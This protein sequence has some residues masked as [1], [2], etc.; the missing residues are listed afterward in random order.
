MGLADKFR[1]LLEGSKLDVNRRFE[2]MREAISGTMSKFYMAKD[3]QTGEVFGLKVCNKQKTDY[4]ENRFA[5]LNK[6]SEGEIASQFDHPLIVTTFKY[7]KTTEGED[8]VLM[9]Y[10]EGS[11]LNSLILHQSEKLNG[12]RARLIQQIVEALQ[13]VHEAGFIHRDVCPRNFIASP[14]ATSIKLIDFGLTVPALPL[15]MQPGNRT[16]TP[17]YM[18]PE[19]VRRR[20]TDKRLDL[21]AFGVT[22]FQLLTRE[23]PWPGV[24]VTGKAAMAHDAMPPREIFELRPKLDR[25]LGNAIKA[26][27]SVQPENRPDSFESFRR[28]INGV[29]EEEEP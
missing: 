9:E 10:L 22:A 19:I 12:V 6:P 2:L 29:T 1:L 3:R 7:G 4:F 17:N 23:L 16:G 24:D 20:K 28:M 8:Y 25:T 26:C 14:D 15:F 27:L 21:F 13:V 11:G 18:A 5:G